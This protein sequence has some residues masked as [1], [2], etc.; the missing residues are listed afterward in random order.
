MAFFVILMMFHGLPIHIMRDVLL[1]FRSFHKRIFDFLRYRNA[2]RDMNSRYPD[3][4]TEELGE[5]N[6]CIICREEM[7]PWTTPEQAQAPADGAQ[8]AQP[9]PR[10]IDERHRAKKLPCGHCLHISCL[11]S[12]LERQQACPT[13]RQP[14]LIE[15]SR[16]RQQANR[17]NPAANVGAQPRLQGDQNQM[18]QDPNAQQPPL[19]RMRQIQFGPFRIGYGVRAVNLNDGQVENMVQALEQGRQ[20]QQQ[21]QQQQQRGGQTD[22][23]SR[24]LLRDA[25][26][27]PLRADSVIAQTMWL[28]Q[29]ERRLTSEIQSLNVAQNQLHLVRALQAEYMRLR[30]VA[31]ATVVNGPQQAHDA[32]S[33]LANMFAGMNT[34]G[35]DLNMPLDQGNQPQ[36]FN[37][38]TE[39]PAMGADDTN[40][41]Q[42]LTL[43]QGWTLLP[44][45][46]A[47]D[48]SAH[49]EPGPQGVHQTHDTSSSTAQS[50][51]DA[52]ASLQAWNDTMTRTLQEAR[53]RNYTPV[54]SQAQAQAPPADSPAPTQ[55]AGM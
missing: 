29:L 39:Q 18:P 4:T 54:D 36:I 45:H 24:A 3:A 38:S 1:T 32:Q 44:L 2:T 25:V 53:S 12:W 28:D 34:G 50:S 11:R 40:L 55:E 26:A 33:P 6:I 15:E 19:P 8:P 35:L 7:R 17:A 30:R 5:N 22:R 47:D 20:Q 13:C 49:R 27:N 16:Q 46:R 41:P 21:L 51:T 52:A 23:S 10:P 37:P 42:G 48:T 43:P 31:A 9:P 14:V